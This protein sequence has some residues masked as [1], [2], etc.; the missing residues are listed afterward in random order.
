L[1]KSVLLNL[2]ESKLYDDLGLAIYTSFPWLQ[3]GGPGPH[4]Q[5]KRPNFPTN[6]PD[7]FDVIQKGWSKDQ[8]DR[9]DV[10]AFLTELNWTRVMMNRLNNQR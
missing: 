1:E 4:G 2:K 7:S 3:N 10:K 8:K 5:S 9:P 6:F